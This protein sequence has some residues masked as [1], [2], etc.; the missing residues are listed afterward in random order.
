MTTPE[1]LPDG[2][3]FDALLRSTLDLAE[4]IP[5]ASLQAAYSAIEMRTLSEE[6]AS[7]V[8]D[9]L[10]ESAPTLMR[11]AEGDTRFATFANEHLTLDLELLGDGQSIVGELRPAA[12]DSV[13][14]ESFN[15]NV[16]QVV[17]DQF[18]RFRLTAAA[19]GPVRLRVLGKLVTP[20]I[21]R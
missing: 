15:G 10:V 16:Q 9:S 8:F 2:D 18:G 12:G 5:E 6:L 19:E 1:I 11:G 14:C 21:T 3:A 7:L 13:E 4:P 17:A 20:W